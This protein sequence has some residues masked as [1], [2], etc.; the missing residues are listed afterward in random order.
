MPTT[1]PASTPHSAWR[2]RCSPNCHTG[3]GEF[4]DVSAQAALVSRADCILGR[5]ITGEITPEDTRADYDQ[6]GPA[7]IFASSNG[8]VYLYMTN[9][10]HWAGLKELMGRPSWLD[11]FDDDWLEFSVTPEK[12][13]EFHSGFASWIRGEDKEPVTEKAQRLGVP[14]V[15]VYGTHELARLPQYRHRGLFV[16]VTHPVLG[17]APYPTVP[18]KMSASPAQITTPAPPLGQHTGEVLGTREPR[19]R[20]ATKSSRRKPPKT[21]R[22]GPLEG[23]RVVE[24]TKVWAGPYAGKL[25]AFLGAEVIKVEN[26]RRPEEMRAYGGTDINHAPFFLSINPEILSVDLDIKTPAGLDRLRELIARSDIVINNLRPGAM[27][28]QGL[29]YDDL[30]AIKSDIISV[31]IKMWGNDGPLGYQTGYAPCFA[32]LAGVLVARRIPGRPAARREHALRGLHRRRRCRVRSG[33][34]ADASRADG[35]GPVRRRISGR[36]SDVDDRRQRAGAG[37]DRSSDSDPTAT[38]IPICPRTA[39][40]PVRNGDWISRRRRRPTPNGMRCVRRSAR[41][42]WPTSPGH[43]TRALSRSCFAMRA[44]PPAR[45]QPRS[46]SSPTNCSGSEAHTASC[47]TTW[48]VSDRYWGRRGGCR[49]NPA[50][51][52]R[53]AP[54]LGEHND[55]VFSVDRRWRP[56]DEDTGGHRGVGDRRQQRYR[57]RDGAGAGSGGCGGCTARAP[58]RPTARTQGGDR[59]GG[60]HRRWSPRPTSPTPNRW[61]PPWQKTVGELGRLDT[62]VNNAGLLRMG[63]AADAPLKDWDDLVSVNVQGVLYATRAALPHLIAAAADSPRGVADVVTISS[64]GG[65]VA[66]PGT[67]VYSLTKFGVNAFSEGIRQELIGKRVRVGIVEPGTVQTEITEHLPPQAQKLSRS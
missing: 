50:R 28:R 66:R 14:L 11:E 42:H 19:K 61:P 41:A 51:I 26:S 53:G 4:I 31:S 57:R 23:V 30:R 38:T 15:P 7:S 34:G 35:R 13:A 54:D 3:E 55:Y 32:A 25:L 39:A 58:R 46:T 47:P 43:T 2:H 6:Q 44:S 62:L 8:H 59:G 16:D 37:P 9:G 36:G 56:D 45:A 60:W 65:R 20:L 48:R 18:Y 63:N 10:A 24:L 64:T 1:R 17:T 33:R 49:R 5:F 29:G 52:E 21:T 27:E 12:V 67:A 22:G 40:T